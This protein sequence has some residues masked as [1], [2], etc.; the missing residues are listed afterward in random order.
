[1]KRIKVKITC[2][3]CGYILIIEDKE[4]LEGPY[5]QCMKC[6]DK[7]PIIKDIKIIDYYEEE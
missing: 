6:D 2:T 5:Y 1:M 4:Y 3:Y 7:H